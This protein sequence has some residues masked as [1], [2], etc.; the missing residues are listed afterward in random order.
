MK[1]INE[2]ATRMK[3]KQIAKMI[4]AGKCIARIMDNERWEWQT[5]HTFLVVAMQGGECPMQE[6]EKQLDMG[7][8]TVSRNVAKLGDGLSPDEPG[9]RLIEAYEDPFWRRR[10]IVRLTEKGKRFADSLTTILE[11]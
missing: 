5:A 8:A 11:R 9:M 2:G 3:S 4:E 1:T 6:I 10:K 7:Q